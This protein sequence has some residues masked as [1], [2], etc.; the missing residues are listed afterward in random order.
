MQRAM[1]KKRREAAAGVRF[2][3]A[4]GRHLQVDF[5]E[6]KLRI[7]GAVVKVYLLVA[8]LSHSRRPSVEAFLNRCASRYF[9]PV[10]RSSPA[11]AAASPNVPCFF[12]SSM[13]FLTR[14]SV[15]ITDF[16][17][18]GAASPALN[19]DGEVSLS[20]GSA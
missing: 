2:E 19:Q 8:L 15:A 16:S 9:A 3:T 14:A 13:S 6:K 4:P 7:G 1:E 5:G 17:L 18:V 11:R 10:L 20:L 12:N